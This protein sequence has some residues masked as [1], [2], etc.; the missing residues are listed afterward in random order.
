MKA[1]TRKSFLA[2]VLGKLADGVILYPRWVFYP[3]LILFGLSIF[4][5]VFY[6]Q[7]DMDRDHLVGSNQIYQKNYLAFRKEFP[8]P[9]DL[10]VVVQSDDI[11]KNRQF[12]ERVGAKLAV[13]TNL[14]ED[15]FYKGD[16]PTLGNKA[17]FFLSEDDLNGLHE[18]LTNEMPFIEKFTQTTNLVSFFAQINTAF[19]TAPRT[20]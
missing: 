1:L 5:T 9:D 11:E 4:Y 17:L 8:Q 16:L 15:V 6:L 10:V 19:R 14:F 20:E 18:A 2:R 3:Q 12:V 7:F 13:E